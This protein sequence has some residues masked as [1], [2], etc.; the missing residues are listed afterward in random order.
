VY[1][2]DRRKSSHEERGQMTGWAEVEQTLMP[3]LRLT[4]RPVAVAF[5]DAAPAG[6]SKLAGVQP[7]GCSF[8]RLAADG[9]AF[10][11]VAADHH[12]CPIGGYTHNIPLPAERA[13]ELEQVLGIMTGLGYVRMEEIP[14]IPRLPRTPGVVVYAP[15]GDTPVDPDVVLV[16]GR[17]GRLMLLLEAAGRAGVATQPGLLGRPTCMALPASLAGGVV[18]STGCIG[19][20]VYTDLGEDELY[21]AISGRDVARVAAE[22][23]TVR[24]AN[25]ALAD[26]H[27]E[28]RRALA[29]E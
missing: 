6:V 9:R 14:D 18:A 16:A 11:T 21:V 19:N 25:D 23:G 7:S 13:G 22:L 17:P 5:R 4:R 26:Y 20:R 10:Y 24:S 1:Y 29:T 8:W 2:Q 3:G 15:L 12:N 28:R 27:R